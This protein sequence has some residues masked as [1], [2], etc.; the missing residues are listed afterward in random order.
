MRKVEYYIWKKK[1][2]GIGQEK[3]LGGFGDFHQFGCGFEETHEGAGSYS[4]AII[5]LADG[6]IVNPPVDMV[7]FMDKG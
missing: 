4:T 1:V 7:K 2:G 3:R 5:E 6:T